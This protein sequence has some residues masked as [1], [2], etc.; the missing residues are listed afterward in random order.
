MPLNAPFATPINRLFG[1]L[2]EGASRPVRISDCDVSLWLNSKNACGVVRLNAR[3]A[4]LLK[5]F[6][7]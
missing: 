7:G 5:A 3:M 4:A 2:V 1:A 6:A